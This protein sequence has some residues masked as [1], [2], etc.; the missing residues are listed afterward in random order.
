MVDDPRSIG[1]KSIWMLDPGNKKE[2]GYFAYESGSEND[3]WIKKAD[4]SP[5]IGMFHQ[6]K[7]AFP[8]SK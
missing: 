3:V 4:G 1:S 8:S 7:W 5:F 2:K 6:L